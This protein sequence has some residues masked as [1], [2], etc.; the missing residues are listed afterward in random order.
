MWHRI[1]DCLGI[2]VGITSR[3]PELAP[4][5]D[6]VFR[7][8]ADAAGPVEVDYLLEVAG[9]PRLVRRHDSWRRYWCGRTATRSAV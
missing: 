4:L 8:Y 7:G 9:W 6:A 2:A 5:L 3:P 1:L